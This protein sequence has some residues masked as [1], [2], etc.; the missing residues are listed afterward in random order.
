VPRFGHR[1][2]PIA[3]EPE[4]AVTVA[5]LTGRTR[6]RTRPMSQAVRK[7]LP[8]RRPHVA[9]GRPYDRSGRR[10]AAHNG[11]STTAPGA[12]PK[13]RRNPRAKCV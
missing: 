7:F 2:K 4:I 9:Q 6:D 13:R 5:A 11:P 8:G 3:T 12:L 1:F 10:A